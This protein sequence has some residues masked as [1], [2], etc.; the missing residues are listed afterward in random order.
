MLQDKV[1]MAKEQYILA[2]KVEGLVESPFLNL[3]LLNLGYEIND[4]KEV[5]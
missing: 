3:K 2:S 5:G 1:D 4:V